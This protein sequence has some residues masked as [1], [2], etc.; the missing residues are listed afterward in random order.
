MHFGHL[1]LPP[2]WGILVEE[3]WEGSIIWPN[4]PSEDLSFA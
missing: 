4:L 2:G 1:I 3:V